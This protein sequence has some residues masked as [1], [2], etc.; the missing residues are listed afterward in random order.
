MLGW[1]KLNILCMHHLNQVRE[2]SAMPR[3]RSSQ[4]KYND[5]KSKSLQ[6]ILYCTLVGCGCI[7][8]N[9]TSYNIQ[10]LILFQLNLRQD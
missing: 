6:K 2:A 3:A 9:T 4:T 1:T 10:N 8:Q 5:K 7:G